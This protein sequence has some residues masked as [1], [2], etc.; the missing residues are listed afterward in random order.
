MPIVVASKS[1]V[2]GYIKLP[3]LNT[4]VVVFQAGKESD[5]YMVEGYIDLREMG[6]GDTVG[7]CEKIAVDGV[8]ESA[9]LCVE[10]SGKQDEPV[11]RF[12]TKTLLSN[13]IYKV[14]VKQL[15]GYLIGIYYGFIKQ[16]LGTA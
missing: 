7:I 16:V 6:T 12:H 3:S 2:Q 14:I 10:L 9:F 13:M 11:L 5:D 1:K 15:Y 8:V 4:D